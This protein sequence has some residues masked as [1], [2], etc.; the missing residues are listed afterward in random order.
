M[1]IYLHSR[2]ISSLVAVEPGEKGQ[3][4]ARDA[5]QH[6]EYVGV[7]GG[8]DLGRVGVGGTRASVGDS[9]ERDE[10]LA[11]VGQRLDALDQLG[12]LARLPQRQGRGDQLGPVGEVPVEAALLI[13]GRVALGL[14]IR[15]RVAVDDRPPP[16]GSPRTAIS[17]S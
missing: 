16:R 3:P 10:A 13:G 4:G 14:N 1:P 11:G 8:G 5:R 2:T 17:V 9:A 6:R 7:G 12:G 15:E